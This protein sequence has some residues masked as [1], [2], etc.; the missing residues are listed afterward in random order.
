MVDNINF[1][2]KEIQGLKKDKCVKENFILIKYEI[3]NE[4]IVVSIYV[5]KR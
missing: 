5:Q 3:N 4:D 2:L 1:R